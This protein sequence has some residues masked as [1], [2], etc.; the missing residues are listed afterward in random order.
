M[1][2][3]SP[4]E[5]RASEMGMDAGLTLAGMFRLSLKRHSC[6]LEFLLI[7]P[8]LESVVFRRRELP[9]CQGSA[10]IAESDLCREWR[11]G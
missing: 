8:E 1:I 7:T 4:R 6:S 5:A 3:L 11:V 10:G 9:F 2:L